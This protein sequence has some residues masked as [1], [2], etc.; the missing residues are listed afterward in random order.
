M[1]DL[2]TA[3]RLLAR[4]P[5]DQI[6][7]EQLAPIYQ[8]IPDRMGAVQSNL[9]TPILP[10]AGPDSQVDVPVGLIVETRAHPNLG[11]IVRQVCD[12]GLSVHVFHGT[13][14]RAFVQDEFADLVAA[15][16]V[17]LTELATDR[18]DRQSYNALLL[19][20]RFWDLSVGRGKL[21]MVQTDAV[22]C[23]NAAFGLTDFLDL[24]YVGSDWGRARPEG[25]VVNGGNG[26]LSLRDW[27]RM[28][29]C[30][31]RFP[32]ANWRGGEDTYFAFHIP[33]TGGV[34]ADPER[35]AAFGSQI[36]FAKRSF[37][38]HKIDKMHWANRV[39]F[40]AYC[41]DAA[42]I[43]ET[44]G[45]SAIRAVA[46]ALRLSGLAAFVTRA[47]GRGQG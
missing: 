27:G 26:G 1:T 32:P 35:S 19:D 4:T 21:L 8:D 30:L 9:V 43:L 28:Q 45:A 40:L 7:T 2:S 22:L 41:P 20:T 17:W 44:P 16:R 23:P 42:R 12:L 38:A 6:G 3:E 33:L 36:R 10:P 47:L 18:M 31:R 37:G 14:N 13:G 25:V 5:A 11:P 39:L 15:G 46:A 34:V 29:E 24:D